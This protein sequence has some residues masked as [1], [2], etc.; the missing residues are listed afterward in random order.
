MGLLEMRSLEVNSLTS[1][2]YSLFRDPKKPLK[3][4]AGLPFNGNC[5]FLNLTFKEREFFLNTR[6]E[7]VPVYPEIPVG[8]DIPL[9]SISGEV[10]VS[11]S[12]ICF[13]ASP[14]ILDIPEDRILRPF[15]Q[16]QLFKADIPCIIFVFWQSIPEYQ[17]EGVRLGACQT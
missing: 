15:I 2:V 5:Q 13:A 6:P 7:Q 11:G 3:H 10:L 9:Q 12:G 8:N 1:Q 16:H 17:K 14:I 4:P